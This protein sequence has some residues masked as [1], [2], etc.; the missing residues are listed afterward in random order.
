MKK[1]LSI[2]MVLALALGTAGACLAE[3]E[4]AAK[5]APDPDPFSGIWECD[6]ASIE[7]VW[8]EEGY[9]VLISWGSSAWGEVTEW[10]YSCYY[11]EDDNTM[12]SMPFGTKTDLVFNDEGELASWQT[13]YE[14]GEAVFSLDE[15][16]F[17]IWQDAKENAGE[18]MR[19]DRIGD[20]PDLSDEEAV[21]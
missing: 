14:D 5:P 15:E 2:L 3:S 16:G 6:R 13:E 9:R 19:F 12:V 17:L 11:H 10:E 21:G 7:I 1:I 18:G 4:P 8:E 20:Y